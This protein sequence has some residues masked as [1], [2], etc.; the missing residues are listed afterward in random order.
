[1][2]HH[3]CRLQ[4][5]CTIFPQQILRGENHMQRKPIRCVELAARTY[6]SKVSAAGGPC[7]PSDYSEELHNYANVVIVFALVE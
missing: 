5:V 2:R 4:Q 7:R 1:M 3:N 6:P